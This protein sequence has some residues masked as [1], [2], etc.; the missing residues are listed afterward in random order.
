MFD[1]ELWKLVIVDDIKQENF[2]YLTINDDLS[3]AQ[4]LFDF[5]D[6]DEIPVVDEN[7]IIKGIVT[8][9]DFVN[10]TRKRFLVEQSHE[11]TISEL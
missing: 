8:R 9:F 7:M 2:Y 11:S 3:K 1:T 5:Y 4:E 6:I 10:F